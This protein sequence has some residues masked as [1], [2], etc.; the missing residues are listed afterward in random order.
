[1]LKTLKQQPK[2]MLEQLLASS[3]D[4]EKIQL[5]NKKQYIDAFEALLTLYIHQWVI[6]EG[7]KVLFASA[8]LEETLFRIDENN[9]STAYV[10]KVSPD[11]PNTETLYRE[12][13]SPGIDLAYYDQEFGLRSFRKNEW[14]FGKQK[15]KLKK[16]Y[17]NQWVVFDKGRVWAAYAK[18][19]DAW[20][21]SRQEGFK[22]A[23]VAFVS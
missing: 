6:F 13:P 2:D 16:N 10:G 22:N 3:K 18:E 4:K 11:F 14:A 7:G 23:V 17:P 5:D 19:N 15:Q 12:M 8:S 9:W 21:Y 20:E 1:M